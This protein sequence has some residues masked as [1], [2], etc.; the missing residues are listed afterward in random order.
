M[1]LQG[2]DTRRGILRIVAF[3]AGG[4]AAW[5]L[6]A[7]EGTVGGPHENVGSYQAGLV[8]PAEVVPL[9]PGVTYQNVLPRNVAAVRRLPTAATVSA[10]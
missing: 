10:F 1:K 6:S 5:A 9:R 8:E 2:S 7:C 3:A 4:A